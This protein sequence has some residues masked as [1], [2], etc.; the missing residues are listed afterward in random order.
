M[1]VTLILFK[2]INN[3]NNFTGKNHSLKMF[4][5]I[6]SGAAF[7]IESLQSPWCCWP[8]Y[9]LVF[10]VTYDF[11]GSSSELSVHESF[12]LHAK[13]LAHCHF[14]LTT[15]SRMSVIFVLRLTI[16]KV[17]LYRPSLEYLFHN[18]LCIIEQLQSN[19][20][21][22]AITGCKLKYLLSSL[23]NAVISKL[24]QNRC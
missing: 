6:Y 9:Q 23:W 12:T 4:I 5:S 22:C 24:S 18:H 2:L 7:P 3:F 16:H 20:K 1:L 14:R 17:I 15:H 21:P 10:I 13:N 19:S 8:I 11:A